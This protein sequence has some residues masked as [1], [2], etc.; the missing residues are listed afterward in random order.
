MKYQSGIETEFKFRGR[1]GTDW[2][3]LL[4]ELSRFVGH[5]LQQMGTQTKRGEYFDSGSRLLRT[6]RSLFRSPRRKGGS[7]VVY[8][9]PLGRTGAGAIV[10]REATLRLRDQELDLA[11]PF[12]QRLSF[13]Q[14][15]RQAIGGSDSDFQRLAREFRPV[16]ELRAT[17]DKFP[18]HDVTAKVPFAMHLTV[19]TVEVQPVGTNEV[20]VFSECEIEVTRAH[21]HVFELLDACGE[22]F[23]PRFDDDTVA[24]CKYAR[25]CQLLGIQ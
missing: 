10:R 5:E 11:D 16:L 21:P 13:V 7:K 1:A 9:H 18:I 14:D 23:A 6:R 19:D 20:A 4:E 2:A 3:R 12:H 17:R 24:D 8:K 22:E 15:M 25:S